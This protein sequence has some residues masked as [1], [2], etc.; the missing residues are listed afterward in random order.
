[1]PK[2]TS[3][4][5]LR[6][7]QNHYGEKFLAWALTTGRFLIILTETIALAAFTYRFSLDRE[8]IDLADSIKNNRA[9]VSLYRDEPTYR[10][11]QERLSFVASVSGS[12]DA[13]SSLLQE[14]VRI[15]KGKVVYQRLTITDTTAILEFSATSTGSLASFMNSLK[16]LSP[17]R[18]VTV[19]KVENKAESGMI[20]VDA[21]VQLVGGKGDA[22]AN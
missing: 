15:A 14:L 2:S 6:R 3:I 18:S 5:L 7:S 10:N 1:M 16:Q 21:T 4:N 22:N 12:L 20:I 19:T 11:L 8:I 9:I 17:I 13:T